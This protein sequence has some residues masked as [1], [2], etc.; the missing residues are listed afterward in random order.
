[1]F[2]FF[3]DSFRGKADFVYQ[4]GE[5]DRVSMDATADSDVSAFVL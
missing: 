5:I 1:M 4:S 2:C 3:L